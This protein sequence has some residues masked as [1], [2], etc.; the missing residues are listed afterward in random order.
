L[1]SDLH[2]HLTQRGAFLGVQVFLLVL[3]EQ[4]QQVDM[5]SRRNVQIQV[6]KS[7]TLAFAADR[8][9]RTRLADPAKPPNQI[10]ALGGLRRF[11]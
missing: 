7:T 9:S 6:A 10:S 1:V 11:D 5:R 4:V 2:R 3:A 8:I